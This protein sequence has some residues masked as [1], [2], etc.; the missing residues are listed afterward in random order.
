MSPAREPLP[1]LVVVMGVSGSGKTTI[2]TLVAHELGVQFIDG[3][4]L[5]PLENVQKMA[6]GTP[7]DDDDRWPW[8][9]IVG[10]TLHEHGERREGLVVACSALKRAYRERIRSQAP[11]ALFLHLDGTL[12]VLTRRIEGRSG[13]FM[14]AALLESQIETLEPLAQEEGGYVLNIDQPV[15]DMVDDAVT[16]LRALVAAQS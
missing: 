14:P 1:P 8:L 11:S 12:E 6:A 2:G 10:R 16:R 13:H 5:H 15:A 4:S 3:D 7:L 9:E